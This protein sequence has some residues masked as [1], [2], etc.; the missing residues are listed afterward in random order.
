LSYN[1]TRSWVIEIIGEVYYQRIITSEKKVLIE[2]I[3]E[4]RLLVR[5]FDDING[6]DSWDSGNIEPYEKPEPFFVQ[7]KVNLQKK[8]TASLI[9]DF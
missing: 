5:A 7:N 8:M 4:Q 1:Q 9:I 3:G 6:N 2:N